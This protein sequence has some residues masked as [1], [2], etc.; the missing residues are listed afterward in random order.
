VF[1]GP[2]PEILEMED[3]EAEC[4][5]VANRLQ[6]FIAAGIQP[7]EIGV[8]VRSPAELPRAEAAVALAGL[9]FHILDRRMGSF[10]GQYDAHGEGPGIPRG[11][12][13]GLRG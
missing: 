10:A 8:F 7:H 3:Q 12:G 9:P 11:C 2:P 1:N 13:D 6:Q 5:T 4:A